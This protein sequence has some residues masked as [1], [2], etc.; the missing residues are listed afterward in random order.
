[1]LEPGGVKARY[2]SQVMLKPDG[3]KARWRFTAGDNALKMEV[4]Q[5]QR[6]TEGGDAPTVE[7]HREL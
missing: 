7:M 5:M 1:M 2:K 3:A 4:Y 6:R